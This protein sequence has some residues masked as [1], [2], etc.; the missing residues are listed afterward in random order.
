MNVAELEGERECTRSRSESE[1]IHLII[2][3]PPLIMNVVSLDS[4]TECQ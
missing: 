4:V 3:F 1:C 2:I